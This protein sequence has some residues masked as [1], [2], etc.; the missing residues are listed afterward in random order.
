MGRL[1]CLVLYGNCG[2]GWL[3]PRPDL[4][5][6]TV[7]NLE[8]KEMTQKLG[9]FT[10]DDAIHK[11][12]GSD[13]SGK[14]VAAGIAGKAGAE[15]AAGAKSTAG[16][17]VGIGAGKLKQ[18]A[19]AP[20]VDLRKWCSQVEDQLNLGSCTAHAAIGIVEYFENRAFQQAH[21]GIAP[22]FV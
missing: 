15:D 12:D 6:Y 16:K 14:N 18:T 17:T 20:S 8:I 1:F 9:I 5:D 21:R 13:T 2:T 7:D 4:R 11:S 3:P 19:P 22:V 10:A